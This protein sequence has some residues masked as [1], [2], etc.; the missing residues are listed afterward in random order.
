MHQCTIKAADLRHGDNFKLNP[1]QTKVYW[2]QKK[3]TIE[4]RPGANK[5]FPDEGKILV[6]TW[7]CKQLIFDP[8]KELFLVNRENEAGKEV[9]N[10]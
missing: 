5:P 9:G 3:W 4:S 2:V 7:N 1:R 6:V 10:G 8:E